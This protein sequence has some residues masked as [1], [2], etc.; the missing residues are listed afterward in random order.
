MKTIYTLSTIV[1]IA[2]SLNGS[3]DDKIKNKEKSSAVSVAPFIWGDPEE[4]APVGLTEANKVLV[5]VAP[6]VWGSPEDVLS[7]SEINKLSVPVAPFSYGNAD[8]DAPEGLQYIKAVNAKVSVAPFVLGDPDM[9][10]PAEIVLL[11]N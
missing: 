4:E 1:L 8:N 9:D 2:L 10:V 11:E 7:V 5:P 3:A 6:F